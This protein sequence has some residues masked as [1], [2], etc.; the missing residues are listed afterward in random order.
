MNAEAYEPLLAVGFWPNGFQMSGNFREM[1]LKEML[2]DVGIRRETDR[3]MF[4]IVGDVFL[5]AV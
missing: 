2:E 3:F 4:P 1:D 5:G